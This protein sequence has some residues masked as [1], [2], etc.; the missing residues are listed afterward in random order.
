MHPGPRALG[1]GGSLG[2]LA[3]PRLRAEKC[4][5]EVVGLTES[6]TAILLGASSTQKVVLGSKL[7]SMGWSLGI[8]DS[9]LSKDWLPKATLGQAELAAE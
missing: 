2:T 9:V 5:G 4:V 6:S 7:L 1:P 8:P 3:H